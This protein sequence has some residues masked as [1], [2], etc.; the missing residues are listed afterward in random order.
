MPDPEKLGYLS[1]SS[2]FS[3]FGSQPVG[4]VFDSVPVVVTY[5]SSWAGYQATHFTKEESQA[6]VVL[7]SSQDLKKKVKEQV[8]I[9][10]NPHLWS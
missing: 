8:C 2:S 1:V 7:W 4:L 5:I 3:S 10:V 6:W 9:S